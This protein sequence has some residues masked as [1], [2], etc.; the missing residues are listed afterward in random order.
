MTPTSSV[1]ADQVSAMLVA[2]REET[3]TFAGAVGACA[4][5]QASV[6]PITDERAEE[7]PASS[8]ALTSKV[9]AVPQAS[10][11]MVVAVCEAVDT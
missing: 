10:P 11:E 6:D 3:L 1:E 9:C 2:V 4:S 8:K 5:G 7:L